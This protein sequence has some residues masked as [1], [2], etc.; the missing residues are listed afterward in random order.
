MP[1]AEQGRVYAT[2]YQCLGQEADISIQ[3]VGAMELQGGVR[4]KEANLFAAAR[5]PSWPSIRCL[6][7]AHTDRAIKGS[8]NEPGDNNKMAPKQHANFWRDRPLPSATHRCR[9]KPD[10]HRL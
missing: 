2:E 9:R 4:S 7:K 1:T 3:R 6:I 5:G 8:N 10:E